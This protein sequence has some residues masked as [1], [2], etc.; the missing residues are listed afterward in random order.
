MALKIITLEEWKNLKNTGFTILF[1]GAPWSVNC[2]L[3]KSSLT[4]ISE[5]DESLNILIFDTSTDLDVVSFF[6][7]TAVPTV[8]ILKDQEVITTKR[9]FWNKKNGVMKKDAIKEWI[10]SFIVEE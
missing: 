10:D 5:N 9:F 4:K 6:N 1:F 7:I 3:V 2:K 8:K